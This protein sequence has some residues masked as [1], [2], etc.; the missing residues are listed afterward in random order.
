MTKN[1]KSNATATAGKE[2]KGKQSETVSKD[3][4][5]TVLENQERKM[6]PSIQTMISPQGPWDFTPKKMVI[7]QYCDNM[8]TLSNDFKRDPGR[9]D[10]RNRH[11]QLRKS[12][13]GIGNSFHFSL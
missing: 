2:S 6:D 4:E 11:G 1:Q 7:T 8:S 12:P 3:M 5:K 10:G 9:T 13:L